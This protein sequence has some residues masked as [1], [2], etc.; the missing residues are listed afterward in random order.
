M[1]TRDNKRSKKDE[2]HIVPRTYLKY[3]KIAEDKNFVYG[4]DF[5]NQYNKRVQIFGLNDKVFKARRYYNHQSFENPYVIEEVFG[6][7][8][9]PGY[10][11]IMSEVN[12]ENNLSVE[13][14][15]KVMQWLYV[16]KMRSPFIRMNMERVTNFVFKTA[17]RLKYKSLSS[18]KEKVIEQH[19]KQLAKEVQINAF[20]F[21]E[22]LKSLIGLYVNTLS[23]KHWRILKSNPQ[24]EFWTND[25]PGF[26][27]NTV[28]RFANNVPYHHV[29]EMNAHSIIFYPLSPKYCL[30]I[31]PVLDGTPV[32]MNA[33]TM[34]IKYE[35]AS[36]ELI[37]FINNGVLYTSNNILVS[38]GKESLEHYI[39]QQ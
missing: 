15:E 1:A 18:E 9:E 2:Q 12:N 16:S 28:E 37:R 11:K 8:I 36:D 20:A 32:N 14:R 3:W 29:L 7:N 27:P 22:Q 33:L 17:E 24:F 34:V 30:E 10:D 31:T 39:Q 19:T 23:V 4:I 5:S 25:N 26:S 13:I 35:Q 38:N 21:D 6:E